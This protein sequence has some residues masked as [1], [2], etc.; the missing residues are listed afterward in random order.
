MVDADVLAFWVAAAARINFPG[1]GM[2]LFPDRNSLKRGSL[3]WGT[4]LHTSPPVLLNTPV[5]P[6]PGRHQPALDNQRRC[7]SSG[8]LCP[9]VPESLVALSHGVLLVCSL[10]TVRGCG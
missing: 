6:L 2:Q 5:C 4:R 3:V 9:E 8:K 10:Q 1:E 7:H